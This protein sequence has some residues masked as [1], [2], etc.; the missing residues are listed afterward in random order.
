[1]DATT[2]ETFLS[3]P[4]GIWPSCC[5][6]SVMLESSSN[7][8]GVA[9]CCSLGAFMGSLQVVPEEFVSSSLSHVAGCDK[10]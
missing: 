10:V 4:L 9:D 7:W 1:M 3:S 5:A 6:Y 8:P 2:L